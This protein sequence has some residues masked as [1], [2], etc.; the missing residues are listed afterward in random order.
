MQHRS[1][2]AR[3][4]GNDLHEETRSTMTD[5]AL[6]VNTSTSDVPPTHKTANETPEHRA[7]PSGPTGR[8]SA[9]IARLKGGQSWTAFL[10]RYGMVWVLIALTI[11]ANSL[12]SGFFTFGNLSNMV[13]QVGPTG[14]V[15]VGMTYAIICGGFDLSVTAVF[16]GAAVVYATLSNDMPLVPAFACTVV[17]GVLCGII[18][19]LVVTR[20]KVNAFIATLGTASLFGG[21][22]LLYSH[23]APVLSNRSGFETLG[24]GKWG[25]VWISVYVLGAFVVA[26]GVVLARTAY[27][28]SVYAVGGNMEAARLA[29][30][31]IN[32]IRVSTFAITSMCAAVGG[33]IVASQTSVGQANIGPTVTLDSIA[34]VIIG[35]TSLLGGEG[36]MWRTVVGI[37]IWGTTNNVFASLALDTSTQLLIQ[38]GILILA[39]AFDSLARQGRR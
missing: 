35:G 15:A 10:L 38:G 8:G 21:A 9:L 22:T 13:S 26:F 18:N 32:V 36:A 39:V 29:G 12:Y 11:F 16:A 2:R 37:L 20:L 19:G 5:T 14:I 7:E 1:M 23:A 33:M 30:M 4:S 17:L 31:R 25:G 27:G 6:K 34:I 3:S 28:R 24:T